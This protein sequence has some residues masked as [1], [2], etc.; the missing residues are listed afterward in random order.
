MVIFLCSAMKVVCNQLVGVMLKYVTYL[1]SYHYRQNTYEVG[2]RRGG[3]SPYLIRKWNSLLWLPEEESKRLVQ[4][5]P[6]LGPRPKTNPSVDRFQFSPV[7]Y[8]KRYTCRMRCGDETS[9]CLTEWH[10]FDDTITFTTR[11]QLNVV[12]N[13]T[14]QRLWQ[15]LRY[16]NWQHLRSVLSVATT[17]YEHSNHRII[18]LS[19]YTD[20]RQWFK[21]SVSC[22]GGG[23]SQNLVKVLYRKQRY[24]QYNNERDIVSHPFHPLQD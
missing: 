21:T 24:L 15:P 11:L 14:A 13:V 7:L 18:P 9:W 16:N 22:E 20:A 23:T 5:V 12:T 8:W 10:K 4:L 3:K 19:L 17:F 1:A 2:E 6:S